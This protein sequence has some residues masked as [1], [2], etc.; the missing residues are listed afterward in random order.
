MYIEDEVGGAAVKVCDLRE[1][2]AG[3][4]GDERAGVSPLVARKENLVLGRTGLADGGHGGLNSGCPA[5]DINVV[6]DRML[7]GR[8]V[9]LGERTP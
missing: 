4:V 1:S 9:S 7:V 2:I 6:L 5:L 8:N 3:A